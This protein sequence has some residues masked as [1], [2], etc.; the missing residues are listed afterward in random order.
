MG[1]QDC[2]NTVQQAV[3]NSLTE[4]E[5]T[6][7]IET[8]QE[9]QRAIMAYNESISMEDAALQAADELARDAELAAT[10]E[11]RNAYINFRKRV[12]ATEYIR[13]NWSDNY[14]LGLESFLVGTNVARRGSRLSV[15]AEQKELSQSYIAG[16]LNDLE[17]DNLLP[18]LSS[19]AMD[20][21]V[22]KA[23]WQINRES[24]DLAGINPD[25]VKIAK[26]IRKWQETA[27]VHANRAGAFIGKREDYI[28]RQSH[29]PYSLSREGFENWK[30][31]ILPKLNPVTFEGVG[32]IDD[33]LKATFDGLE[34]GVHL[35]TTPNKS[36]FKGP[37]NVAKKVSQERVLHFKDSDS[38]FEYNQRFGT[39]SLREAV[40]GGLDQMGQ[41][42]A[43]MRRL[44]TNPESNWNQV[45][46][47]LQND[48]KGNN[49][50][51]KALQTDRR[52]K[53]DNRFKE[54]DGT[55]RI[56]QSATLARVSSNLRAIESMAKLGG[57]VVSAVSDIPVAASE[58]KYQGKSLLGSMGE[59]MGGLLK[60]K[61]SDEQK[62]ILSSLGV[63][64]DSA[65]GDMVNRFSVD[66]SL[67]GK[68]SRAQNTFFKLNGLR[69]W[70][71]TMRSSA[72]LMMSHN[73]AL[74]S[75][76]PF[77][78][79]GDTGRVLD[80]Y[81]IDGS[82]WDLIRRNTQRADDGRSYI[83]T[84]GIDDIPDADL[85]SIIEAQGLTANSASINELR[86][87]LKT[88]VR[89]F[90]TDRASYAVIEPDARTRAIMRQGTQPGTIPG[91]LLRFIGQF[92]AFPASILQKSV[93]RELYGRGYNPTGYG[94]GLTPMKEL[95]SALQNGNGEVLGLAQLMIW[96]TVFGYLAMSAKDILK[97]R[98]PRN[99]DNPA[100]WTAAMLQGGALGI[101]G[102]FLFGK[103]NR[104]GDSLIQ[105]F[106]GPV[107]GAGEDL[108]ELYNRIRTGDDAAAASFRFM[109]NNTPFINLFYTRLALDYLI[110]Y[111]I[112]EWMNPGYLRRME[113]R[114]KKENSQEFLL[115]PSKL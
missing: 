41:T 55:T 102:D 70:T 62:E 75:D 46:D 50:A 84:E 108:V 8:L 63:F 76:L 78:R 30:A 26:A 37:R 114:M 34:S 13:N 115:R 15:A 10:I 77:D 90:I 71:D 3:G 113:R 16:L 80:M 79:L 92:K 45:L 87:S 35:K 82:R 29:D 12:E 14:G 83:T 95:A 42:T 51:M 25:A 33:F 18:M 99:P 73:L 53:L 96:T 105:S 47:S 60:G 2:I 61:K 19:G 109:L 89:A 57:A 44:G 5:L 100:V 7:I 69:W 24:P 27:R 86:E 68:L 106:A 6:E 31:F 9:R 66:D 52:K 4:A 110:F 93:G 40:L 97:G 21:D 49:D 101:Y 112:Q 103:V 107:L 39:G 67:G 43:L 54:V 64:F 98:T 20:K 17:K 11:Q 91:E 81:G 85:S 58:L 94:A 28:T 36:G 111:Q 48:L 72:A 74:K 1:A 56:P 104:H 22:S 59:L 65:R 32:N 38:W 88:Q 23:L